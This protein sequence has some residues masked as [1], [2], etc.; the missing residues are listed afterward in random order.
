MAKRLFREASE[1]TKT[2]MSIKKQGCNNPNYGKKRS[3]ETRK[4]ISNSLK[5]AWENIPNKPS[6]E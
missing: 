6:N 1:A 5:M 2:L 4:K 3:E